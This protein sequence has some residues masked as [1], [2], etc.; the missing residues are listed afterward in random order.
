MSEEQLFLIEHHEHVATVWLNR[1][2]K[3]NAMTDTVFR[4]LTTL[5]R[6]LDQD[7]NVRAI[8]LAAKGKSFCAGLDLTSLSQMPHMDM[9][10]QTARNRM[11]LLGVVR[12]WQE[13]ISA[14]ETC[15][16]PVIAAIHGACVGAGLDLA[17]AC[18][19]RLASQ[20]AFFSLREAA[21]AITADLGSLQRLPR[22][23]GEGFTREMAYTAGDYTA[24]Q[25][26]S[27]RLLNRVVDSQEALLKAAQELAA[28]I[29]AQS[30]LAVQSSKE[31]LNFSRDNTIEEGLQFAAMRN[32]MILP[33][34]E[35]ME[36]FMAFMEKRKPSF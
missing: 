9:M 1:P 4:R 20:D 22:I 25:A 29:A 6:G 7:R 16:K 31:T 13:G 32:A 34:E 21:M 5:F 26:F 19:I 28:Q 27:M 10:E 8:V 23:I 36:A 33:S 30:P 2:N 15:R 11:D 14:V 17:A 18:D 3:R 24:E 35:L 12:D